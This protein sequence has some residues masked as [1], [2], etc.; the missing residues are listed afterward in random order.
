MVIF[1]SHKFS[2]HNLT[3]HKLRVCF[4]FYQQN[5]CLSTTRLITRKYLCCQETIE[6]IFTQSS[7]VGSRRCTFIFTNQN[8]KCVCVCAF[9]SMW[10]ATRTGVKMLPQG[11]VSSV[12]RWFGEKKKKDALN[13]HGKIHPT[14]WFLLEL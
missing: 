3:N 2:V 4:L 1:M 10:M 11:V 9:G 14:A 12:I 13:M 7:F 6:A 8:K 5:S